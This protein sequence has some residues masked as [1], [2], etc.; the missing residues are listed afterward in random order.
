MKLFA[1]DYVAMMLFTIAV[2]LLGCPIYLAPLLG[3]LMWRV[4]AK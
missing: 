2:I 1:G 3:F 4:I